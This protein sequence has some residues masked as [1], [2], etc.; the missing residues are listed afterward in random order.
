MCR[1]RR[2]LT[3]AEFGLGLASAGIAAAMKKVMN[4]RLVSPRKGGARL[5]VSSWT[6]RRATRELGGWRS[7]GVM[8]KV[9][10]GA[11]SEE[12]GPRMR[13]ALKRVSDRLLNDRFAEDLDEPAALASEGEVGMTRSVY[14]RK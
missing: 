2:D 4:G 9:F 6:S 5:Y 1:F 12:A 8:E 13:V 11:Q 3:R 7:S 10:Q 14:R